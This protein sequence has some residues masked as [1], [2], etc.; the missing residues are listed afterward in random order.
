MNPEDLDF[1]HPWTI[2]LS[3]G[4]SE[5][6]VSFLDYVRLYRDNW[7]RTQDGYCSRHTGKN[8]VELMHRVIMGLDVGE[9][10]IVDHKNGD[11]LDNRRDNL[12]V[13]DTAANNQNKASEGGSSTYRG[14]AWKEEKEAWVAYAQVD[15]TQHHVG[16]YDSEEEAADAVRS[17]RAENLEFSEDR[18]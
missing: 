16:Y 11:R 10:G 2:P 4:E 6:K 13:V 14:V 9:E 8:T 17:W 7:H 3:D 5:A 1:D 12:R 15:G 18:D